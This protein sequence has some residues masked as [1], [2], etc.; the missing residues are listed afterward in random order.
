MSPDITY[1]HADFKA[2]C[3]EI[4]LLECYK[5]FH[6][7]LHKLEFQCYSS[8]VREVRQFPNDETGREMLKD[9]LLT[10]EQIIEESNV[11]GVQHNLPNSDFIWIKELEKSKVSLQQAIEE[12]DINSLN[13]TIYIINQTIN[14]IPN[15]VNTKISQVAFSLRVSSFIDRTTS[16]LNSLTNKNI[17]SEKIVYC[18]DFIDQLSKLYPSLCYVVKQHDEWQAID[19]RLRQI[20]IIINDFYTFKSAWVSL[21]SLMD[22]QFVSYEEDWVT[23][24]RKDF[25]K[26]ESVILAEDEVSIKKNFRSYRRR[27]SLRFYKL[28][29]DLKKICSNLR[30]ICE[31]LL[32]IILG[33]II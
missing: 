13:F 25:E 12:L 8:I 27:I 14:N 23:D 3:E 2:A 33:I 15:L 18:Q 20:E 30:T 26:L 6:D 28:D 31:Q 11:L 32:S 4:L 29:K 7:L 9:S 5:E 21:K 24:L 10:L 1:F 16:I 19:W 22:L 17:N